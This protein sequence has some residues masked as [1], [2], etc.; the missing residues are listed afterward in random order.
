MEGT[1]TI[2]LVDAGTWRER[3]VVTEAAD[4][5]RASPEL[6]AEWL[7]GGSPHVAVSVDREMVRF[8]TDGEGLGVVTYRITDVPPAREGVPEHHRGVDDFVVLER[9]RP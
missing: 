4:I 7:A 2:M 1:C 3:A 5:V 6:V 8:G 9:V